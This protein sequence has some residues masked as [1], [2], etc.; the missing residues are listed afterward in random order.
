MSCV[1]VDGRWIDEQPELDL[2]ALL[3]NVASSVTDRSRFGRERPRARG[4]AA[5]VLAEA[6]TAVDPQLAGHAARVAA[7][8]ERVAN[9]MGLPGDEVKDIRYAAILHDI[10]KFRVP[11]VILSKPGPLAAD[12]WRL[13]HEHPTLG[14]GILAA[15]P[16][17]ARVAETV[18]SHHERWDGTGYPDGLRGEEIPLGARIVA[19]A[20]AFTAM[21]EERP[22]R[23][24]R[25]RAGALEELRRHA[26]T[27]FDPAVVSVF[28]TI[29]EREGY[30]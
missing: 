25:G 14:A 24:A 18:R 2:I 4:R 1:R 16:E 7:L 17:L 10:G 8:A 22:Y 28:L 5:L 27:Q 13:V 30:S 21:L 6:I 19:V 29:L 23:M 26:G 12:E 9:A 3:K 20:D 15:I 11:A